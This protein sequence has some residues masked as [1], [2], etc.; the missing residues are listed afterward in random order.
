[1]SRFEPRGGMELGLKGKIALV[2]GGSH[3]IGLAIARELALEGCQIIL[4]SRSAGNLMDAREV[5]LREAPTAVVFTEAFEALDPNSVEW[6]S[7]LD[8]DILVNN[9]GGGGRWGTNPVDTPLHTWDEVYQKNARAAVQLTRNRLPYM[10]EQDWGRVV[11]IS[12]IHGREAGS[13][14]WF[15]MAKSAEIAMMKGLAM[16]YLGTGVTFNTVAPGYI[17]IQ[18]KDET[19]SRGTPADVAS[20]VAFLCSQQARHIN[21]ACLVVDGGESRAF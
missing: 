4:A 10:L 15:M 18:C 3:G 5:I 6:L 11:N 1:M 7:R 19:P 14:P 17:Y 21:G 2:T 8:V 9:V 12:S 20:A 13:N 16:T